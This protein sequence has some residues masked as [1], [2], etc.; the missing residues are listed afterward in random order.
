[1]QTSVSNIPRPKEEIDGKF[2]KEEICKPSDEVDSNIDDF[3]DFE[4]LRTSK[5]TIS[6]IVQIPMEAQAVQFEADF[7][8]FYAFE[9]EKE[10]DERLEDVDEFD[11][12]QDFTSATSL[13]TPSVELFPSYEPQISN[14][15]IKMVFETLFP[16]DLTLE[17]DFRTVP[18]LSQ[19]PML[20]TNFDSDS[21]LNFQWDNSEIRKYFLKSIGIDCRA[22]SL[23][24]NK[25]SS[26]PRFAATL[27]DV[28]L[29]PIKPVKTNVQQPNAI[30]IKEAK[31]VDTPKVTEVPVVEFDWNCPR[32]ENPPDGRFIQIFSLF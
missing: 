28:P 8:Q 5:D 3:G 13:Q 10:K 24:K 20:I 30:P 12:F 16:K 19:T 27:G 18:D 25:N 26:M 7:T 32:T 14:E 9:K 21:A 15:E 11:D 23:Q 1:M 4:S 29:E 17:E 22:I 31:K 6:T 2:Y